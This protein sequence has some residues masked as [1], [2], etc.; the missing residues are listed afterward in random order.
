[1]RASSDARPIVRLAD[2]AHT[3]TNVAMAERSGGMH[4]KAM[5]LQRTTTRKR[6]RALGTLKGEPILRRLGDLS[7]TATL[8]IQKLP[9]PN[10]AL[11][12]LLLRSGLRGL[13]NMRRAVTIPTGPLKQL[14]GGRGRGSIIRN[15]ARNDGGV[16]NIRTAG[17][18]VNSPNHLP[19]LGVA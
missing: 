1:M 3:T 14:R 13:D 4:P 17:R 18:P 15:M 10:R 19:P 2:W 6:R 16:G 11:E 8:L 9:S 12:L 7:P 5:H